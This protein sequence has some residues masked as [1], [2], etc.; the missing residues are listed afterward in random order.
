MMMLVGSTHAR[1]IVLVSMAILLQIIWSFRIL[2]GSDP[3]NVNYCYGDWKGFRMNAYDSSV[4]HNA[5]A[6]RIDYSSLAVDDPLFVDMPWPTEGGTPES[7]AFANHIQWKRKLSDGESECDCYSLTDSC[8]FYFPLSVLLVFVGLRWHRWAIY[9]RVGKGA[10]FEYSTQDYIFQNMLAQL[11]S[12]SEARLLSPQEDHRTPAEAL[13]DSVYHSL[14]QGSSASERDEVTAVMRAYYSAFNRKNFDELRYLW[15][16]DENSELTLP[17]FDK[18][19]RKY[20]VPN[21]A[22]PTLSDAIVFTTHRY[23]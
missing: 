17:G 19:V 12:K 21:N 4:V 22:A 11:Q 5:S 15:L 10:R 18:V 2:R 9:E 16:P 23:S 13:Q 8:I 1:V 14:Q 20:I 3:K 7:R 6:A